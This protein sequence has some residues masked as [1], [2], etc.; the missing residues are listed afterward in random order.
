MSGSRPSIFDDKIDLSG[1]APKDGPE[2]AAVPLPN[3]AP[4]RGGGGFPQP[5]PGSSAAGRS[6]AIFAKDRPHGSPECSHHATS[7]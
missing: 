6:K 7:T 4:D 1:F 3:I 5:R 2:P